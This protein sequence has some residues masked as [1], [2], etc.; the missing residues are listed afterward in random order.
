[1]TISESGAQSPPPETQ[2]GKQ[3]GD[4]PASGKGT[5][6]IDNKEEVNK[7]GLEVYTYLTLAHLSVS[8]RLDG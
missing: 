4:P 1:M 3:L 2:T 6:K 7:A 5:D 8:R